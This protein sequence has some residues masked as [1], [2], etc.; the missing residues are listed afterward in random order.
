MGDS[1]RGRPKL[2][3]DPERLAELIEL[4]GSPVNLI[5]P[6]P[7]A[8]NIAALRA[9]GRERGIEL[10]VYFA[11]K[12][13]KCL[14]L[15]DEA[16]EDAGV[17]VASE[18]ELSQVLAR[19]ADPDRVIL[20]A[21]VKPRRLIESAV[22]AGVT[23]S[24]DNEDELQLL[25]ATTCEA[26]P[27][28]A[29]RLAPAGKATRFG[30]S[31]AR[32]RE[33]ALDGAAAR[34]ELRGVHF[35]LDG[36]DAGE[37][38]AALEEAIWL[39][40]QLA[41]GGR[42]VSFVDMGGGVPMS[43]LESATEWES[44]WRRHREALLG[45]E[46]PLTFGGHGL[47]QVA[48]G[49]R[50]FGEPAVYPFHQSPVGAEWLA[51]VLDAPISSRSATVAS[52]LADRHL[53]LRCE[54]GRSL[55]DGCGL[56]AARVEF[57]KRHD[58]RAAGRTGHEPHPVPIDLRRLHGRSSGDPARGRRGADQADRRLS[59]GCVLHRARTADLAAAAI[60]AGRSGGRHRD[61]R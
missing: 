58:E 3:S 42:P 50:V 27:R 49:D 14:S 60:P 38:V 34:S 46:M 54:P 37:R 41:E 55:L 52:A 30:L 47:G 20:T 17:D 59:R 1:S 22:A 2:A 35:H 33:L 12:A 56:T 51:S 8:G 45:Q 26:P 44:F 61:L 32:I 10:G 11:R 25:E 40:D 36:Y 39:A 6:R 19:G 57:R 29:M 18:D 43:Y 48:H 5:D 28:I 9:A 16:V 23:V 13:N 15:V 24:V 4:H 53:E 21:A 31:A 7:M